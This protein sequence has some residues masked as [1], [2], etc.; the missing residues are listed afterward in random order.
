V[1]YAPRPAAI[2]SPRAL[3]LDSDT[4]GVVTVTVTVVLGA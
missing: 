3:T 4:T 2:L 1:K